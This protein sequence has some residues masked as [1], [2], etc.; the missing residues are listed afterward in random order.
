[1][2]K[3][4]NITMFHNNYLWTMAKKNGN[5]ERKHTHMLI[6][7]I[8]CVSYIFITIA[9]MYRKYLLLYQLIACPQVACL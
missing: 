4:N 2:H 3:F 9:R 1:M 6:N 7:D 8:A 5:V